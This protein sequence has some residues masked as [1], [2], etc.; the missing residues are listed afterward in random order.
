MTKMRVWILGLAA[1]LALAWAAEAMEM[2]V[3]SLAKRARDA[4]P[5]SGKKVEAKEAPIAIYLDTVYKFESGENLAKF[6]AAPEK[7]AV[8]D[9]PVSKDPVRV[10]DA[11]DKSEHG[12]RTWYFC[13]SD[14]KSKFDSAPAKY[15]SYLCL[16]CGMTSLIGD[17]YTVSGAIDGH[18]FHF[19]CNDCKKRVEKDASAFLALIVPEGGVKNADGGEPEKAPAKSGDEHSGHSH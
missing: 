12:G 17:S 11:K 15:A 1:L 10:R 9:C 2:G 3:A 7:F 8:V 13:S 6:R 4:D 16:A 19:C 18:A 5:V 14:C